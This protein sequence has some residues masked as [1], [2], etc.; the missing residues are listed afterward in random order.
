MCQPIEEG[1]RH[2]LERGRH[3]DVPLAIHACGGDE[4]HYGCGVSGISKDYRMDMFDAVA[5]V[6]TEPP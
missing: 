3:D 5:L 4:S 1:P 6:L 2:H